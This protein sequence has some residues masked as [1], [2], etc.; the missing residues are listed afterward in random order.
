MNYALNANAKVNPKFSLFK[1]IF[2]ATILKS[3]NLLLF[4]FLGG[5]GGGGSQR[6]HKFFSWGPRQWSETQYLV[7]ETIQH[8][9][10]LPNNWQYIW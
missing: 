6:M 7:R 8:F 9:F 10:L 1:I 4:F 2:S 5:G 3:E